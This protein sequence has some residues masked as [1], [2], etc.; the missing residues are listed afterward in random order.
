MT[1]E[2][3]LAGA[4]HVGV[5]QRE[6]DYWNRGHFIEGKRHELLVRNVDLPI[7]TKVYTEQVVLALL[8]Q[9]RSLA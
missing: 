3:L 1:N 9:A 2:E 4:P 8:E 5:V 7:G 6:P